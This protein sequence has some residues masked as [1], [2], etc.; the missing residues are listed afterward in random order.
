MTKYAF[1]VELDDSDTIVV[2][3]ALNM[4]IKHYEDELAAGRGMTVLHPKAVRA[5]E[6]IERLYENARQISGSYRNED[7]N[8]TVW[9]NELQTSQAPKKD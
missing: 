9:L 7:G 1:T 4:L 6:I 2:R 5:G 3:E 8:F